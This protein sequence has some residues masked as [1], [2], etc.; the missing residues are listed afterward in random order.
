MIQFNP[1]P[2]PT[3]PNVLDAGARIGRNFAP[4]DSRNL[5][6]FSKLWRDILKQ[7]FKTVRWS[8][9]AIPKARANAWAG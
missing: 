4:N 7:S 9:P 6:I 2:Q 1:L 8:S 3:G 5:S